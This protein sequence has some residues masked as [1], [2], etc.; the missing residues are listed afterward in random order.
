MLGDLIKAGSSLISG[1]MGQDAAEE[2]RKMQMQIAANNIK[3][4]KE[5]AQS[6]IQ[7][8]TK[9]AEAAGINPLYALGASTTSF[10]PVSVGVG[11]DMSMPNAVARMGQDI[12]RAVDSGSTSS[13]KISAY[14]Q[15]RQNL[16]LENGFL[17]NQLLSAQI[18]KLRQ[19]PSAPGIPSEKA[20]GDKEIPGQGQFLPTSTL[21]GSIPVTEDKPETHIETKAMERQAANPN[22]PSQEAGAITDTAV[23]RSST[24]YPVGRSKDFMDRADDDLFASFAH[25]IRNRLRPMISKEY[26][27]PPF[28][29]P[30]NTH[31]YFNPIVQEY[32]LYRKGKPNAPD[33]LIR[34]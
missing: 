19:T 9:D 25:N 1:F 32:Q 18:A 15:Q 30:E 17:N 20:S 13:G 21:R 33:Q 2:N 22:R 28:K 16:Q 7:W 27:D 8:K 34:P 12:G 24:G 14:E 6:G 11:P 5:F 3:M 31:W 26:Y 4:Q 10:S 23:V 29:A